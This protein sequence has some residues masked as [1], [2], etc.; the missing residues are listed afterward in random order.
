MP[1]LNLANKSL[2]YAASDETALDKAAS[3]LAVIAEYDPVAALDATTA[4]NALKHVIEHVAA[5]RKPATPT[6]V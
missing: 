6:H 3:L 4:L 5:K 1:S 2:R